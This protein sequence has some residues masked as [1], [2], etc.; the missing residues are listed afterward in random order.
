MDCGASLLSYVNR[1]RRNIQPLLVYKR[2]AQTPTRSARARLTSFLPNPNNIGLSSDYNCF[3]SKT[4]L[5]GKSIPF[6]H[7]TIV[8]SDPR[9]RVV[10]IDND[11]LFRATCVVAHAP[12]NHTPLRTRLAPSISIATWVARTVKIYRLN[13][14]GFGFASLPIVQ[15]S[16]KHKHGATCGPTRSS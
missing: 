7:A 15:P 12:Q 5:R 9:I 10:C 16:L 13:A 2:H 1:W 4:L 8:H 11:V 3:N 6:A 14:H